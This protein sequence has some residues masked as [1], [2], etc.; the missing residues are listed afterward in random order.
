MLSNSKMAHAIG[1]AGSVITQTNTSANAI[2]WLAS[3]ELATLKMYGSSDDPLFVASEIC[4]M[5]RTN[6]YEAVPRARIVAPS[7]LQKYVIGL[8]QMMSICRRPHNFE[9]GHVIITLID[10]VLVF[11]RGGQ[12]PCVKRLS[13]ELD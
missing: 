7:M 11:L 4:L 5:L 9:R 12:L 3:G 10:Q 8:D 6:L 2:R 1:S 13:F